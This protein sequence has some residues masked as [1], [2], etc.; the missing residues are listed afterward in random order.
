MTSDRERL[1][2][3]L[4]ELVAQL[5]GDG[6]DGQCLPNGLL[7]SLESELSASLRFLEKRSQKGVRRPSFSHSVAAKVNL[8]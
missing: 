5:E 1:L 7:A 8:N 6:S 2:K 3:H 4:R